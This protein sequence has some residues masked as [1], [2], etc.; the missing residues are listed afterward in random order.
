[1]ISACSRSK[2]VA[3][4]QAPTYQPPAPAATPPRIGVAQAP[5][6]P[7]VQDAV[8][9]IFKD[10]AVVHTD[11][12]P[13]FLA[14]DFNGDASQDLAVV[15]KPTPDK[16][17]EMNQEY[18]PWLLRDPRFNSHERKRLRVDK[19]EALLAVIHGFGANDWRD[20]EATQTF[21]LKNVVGTDL[22]V[23]TPSEFLS[24]NTGRKLPRPQGD[25]IGEKLNG[26]DGYL[27]YAV[28]TYSWYDPKTFRGQQESGVFHKPRPLRNH[29][30]KPLRAHAQQTPQVVNITAEELKAKLNNNE[31]VTIID[32]RSSQGYAA[33]ST[34]IKGAFHV[35]LRRLKSR[36]KY[37]PLKDVPKDREIVTYCACPADESSITAAQTLQESGFTRVRVLK[38]GWSE[39]NKAKGPVQPK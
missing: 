30:E 20:P 36:L 12:N 23:Q 14:G 3:V 39:W 35:K 11:Y 32:V 18:P 15:L 38:G 33:S 31:P 24:T 34:T 19:D 21:V 22:R 7:E 2:P 4:E 17:D 37:A 29:A 27:Y 9:R 28:A 25:L 1:M 26:T 8:K 10:A 13:S 6:L 16:L 5:K